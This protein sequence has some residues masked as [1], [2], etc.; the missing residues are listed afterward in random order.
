MTLVVAIPSKDFIVLGAD[1]R[2]TVQDVG[3]TRVEINEIEKIVKVAKHVVM[4]LYGSSEEGNYLARE[5]MERNE[6]IDGATKVVKKFAVF[7]QKET[8]EVRRESIPYFG[9]IIAGLDKQGQ[10]YRIPRCYTLE[11]GSGFMPGLPP[12]PY[13]V[14][15]KL[16][17]ALFF[18]G[19]NY[20]P[21]MGLDELC[22]LVGQCIYDVLCVD[23]DVGGRIRVGIIDERG[24]RERP[25]A[26]VKANIK[27]RGEPVV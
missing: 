15:G 27:Q 21:D 19:Q 13:A 9:F 10:K 16:I 5:F 24:F 3:G 8:K 1:S 14:K 4:L 6:H 23:G 20:K 12:L 22:D 11:S 25:S 17:L 26:N 7:C 2:V 18:F